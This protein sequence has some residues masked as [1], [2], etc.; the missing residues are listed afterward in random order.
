MAPRL[1]TITILCSLFLPQP[2]EPADKITEC[3]ALHTILSTRNNGRYTATDLGEVM[4][5]LDHFR[6]DVLKIKDRPPALNSRGAQLFSGRIPGTKA[7]L[8][9]RVEAIRMDLQRAISHKVDENDGSTG[10]VVMAKVVRGEEDVNDLKLLHQEVTAWLEQHDKTSRALN[11]GVGAA[12]STNVEWVV[13]Y[14]PLIPLA[15][16]PSTRPI[17][18]AAWFG[19]LAVGVGASLARLGDLVN[20]RP[21]V[22]RNPTWSAKSASLRLFNSPGYFLHDLS[23]AYLQVGGLQLFRLLSVLQ[24]A[25]GRGP[26][27]ST[28]LD[29]DLLTFT[30]PRTKEPVAIP[31]VRTS[32]EKPNYPRKPRK[33]R[34]S[35]TL[36]AK[37]RQ[38]LPKPVPLPVQE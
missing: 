29:S 36:A 7:G 21:I 15:L 4:D 17:F 32:P 20:T 28:Y 3:L 9:S 12:F 2:A 14:A 31:V 38:L 25:L 16:H 10:R 22:G 37:L 33:N 23:P 26:L 27:R 1:I 5:T 30:D 6:R 18:D 34:E 13:I 35:E 8:A 19:G 11:V 24:P